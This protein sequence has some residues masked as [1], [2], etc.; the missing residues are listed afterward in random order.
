MFQ[1]IPAVDIKGGKCVRLYQG[2][3]D[4]EK[5][6]FEN[7]VEVAKRWETEG[8]KRIHVVDL[9][10]AFEGIPKNIAIVEKIV[11]NVTVPVQFGGG[12]RTIEALDRLFSIGVDRVV[13]GTVAVEEPELFERMVKKYPGKIVLGIDA[14]GGNVTTRGWVEV[15]EIPAVELARK[16]DGM[17]IWG[18][19]Y[20][21][22]SRDGTLTSPNFEEVERFSKNVKKPVIASGGVSKVED[23][24]KLSEI[25]NVAGAIVGKALYEG[26]VSLREALKRIAV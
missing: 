24:L 21:D 3:A 4:Q 25:E 11:K 10:G 1:V 19:V 22:I 15:T 13:V 12:V 8:A 5:V 16:Y 7:P 17:D 20:T 2:R 18:F 14:K 6:Y 23:I 26:K 9:D